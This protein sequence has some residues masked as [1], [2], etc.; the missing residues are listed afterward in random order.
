MHLQLGSSYYNFQA[1]QE[2]G[3]INRGRK[4]ESHELD[5]AEGIKGS[6]L[7]CI[8]GPSLPIVLV[9]RGPNTLADRWVYVRVL[10]HA[11]SALAP[12]LYA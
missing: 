9:K 12:L 3:K 5:P 10:V 7:N 2:K 1:K 11:P 6:N 4:K 8:S